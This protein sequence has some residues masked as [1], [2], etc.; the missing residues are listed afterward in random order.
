MRSPQEALRGEIVAVLN[1]GSGSCD[2][3]STEKIRC[4]FAEAGLAHAHVV[5]VDPAG[6]ETALD[7]AVAKAQ[8]LVVLGGDGTIAT[9]ANKCGGQGPL[10]IPLPGGTMNMLP[11]ALYG[12]LSWQEALAATLAKP[13][14]QPVSGGEI[15]GHRFYCAAILGAPSLWA[16]AREAVREG[17]LLDAA[18]KAFTAT[19]RSLSDDVDYQF[20][21]V[22]GSAEAVAVICPLISEAMEPEERAFE[23]V[24][25]DPTTAAGLF[26]LAFHAVYDGWRNDASVTSVKA[27]DVIVEGHGTLPMILDGEK[28]RAGRKAKVRFLP[29]AFDA[30][31]PDPSFRAT[32]VSSNRFH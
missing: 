26:G 31:V 6:L 9:A 11:K 2:G 14:L 8:V 7:S 16:D 1:T 18:Q 29:T 30:I 3:T 15:D 28:V 22:A 27:V 25:L 10:L 23:A 4:V 17:H 5:S 13:T 12:N 21:Q 24:A 19:R 32:N 20:G